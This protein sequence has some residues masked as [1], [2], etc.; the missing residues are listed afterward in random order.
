M[1]SDLYRRRRETW[2]CCRLGCCAL[3]VLSA[4]SKELRTK[5]DLLLS[6]AAWC[7]YLGCSYT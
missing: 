4:L 6:T 1:S 7:L 3:S 2:R 5:D